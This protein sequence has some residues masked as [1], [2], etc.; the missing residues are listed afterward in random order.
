MPNQH[1]RHNK[2]LE[3]SWTLSSRGHKSV[4][5]PTQIIQHLS[6]ILNSIDMTVSLAKTKVVTVTKIAQVVLSKSE[7]PI[8][9]VARLI[10]HMVSCFPGVNFSIVNLR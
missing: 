10:G 1:C 2:S 7:M 9:L 4:T 8:R 5:T 6:F 3:E